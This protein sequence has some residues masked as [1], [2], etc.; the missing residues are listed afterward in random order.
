[1]SSEAKRILFNGIEYKRLN[2]IILSSEGSDFKLRPHQELLPLLYKIKYN[3]LPYHYSVTKNVKG[4]KYT[5]TSEVERNI[6]PWY[7][8][9]RG[10][11]FHSILERCSFLNN[12]IVTPFV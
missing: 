5:S 3:K 4:T 9:L 11:I 6:T 7:L 8:K 10:G 1:M 2:Y 12:S